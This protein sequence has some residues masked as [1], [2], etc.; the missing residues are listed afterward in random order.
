MVWN[1]TT[2]R[3]GQ[4]TCCYLFSASSSGCVLSATH[5]LQIYV[6]DIKYSLKFS[7][8]TTISLP[9][10]GIVTVLWIYSISLTF[11]HDFV[12]LSAL[13]PEHNWPS[14]NI[15][16]LR[17]T[18][19]GHHFPDDIFKWI[20]LNKKRLISLKIWLK[21]VPKVPIKNIPALVQIMPWR[22]PGD[23]PLSETMMI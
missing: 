23:K 1:T 5:I 6:I 4:Q 10:N 17:P 16:T 21:F 2:E 9:S 19:N 12:V 18:Q 3:T 8:I 22:R 20:F 14:I 11:A 7:S 15:N 13:G